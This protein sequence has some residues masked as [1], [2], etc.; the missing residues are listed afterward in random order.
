ME[1]KQVYDRVDCNG[2]QQGDHPFLT[3][4]FNLVLE[5]IIR[6]GKDITSEMIYM[7]RH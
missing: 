1:F 4:F 5:V 2:S 6:K 3:A 7:N